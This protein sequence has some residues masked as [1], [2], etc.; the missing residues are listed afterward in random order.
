M[1][2]QNGYV[3]E[4]RCEHFGSHTYTLRTVNVTRSISIA[5]P[6]V[7]RCAYLQIQNNSKLNAS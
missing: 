5:H 4:N 6:A 2:T 7:A 1:R 3:N